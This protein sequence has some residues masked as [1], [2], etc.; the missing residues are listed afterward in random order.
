MAVVGD[1]L[2]QADVRAIYLLHG[3]FVG[4][5]AFGLLREVARVSRKAADP[6]LRFQKQLLDKIAKDA[7]NFPTEYAQAFEEAIN[8]PLPSKQISVRL[9]NW[10]S[11]NHHIGRCD[12]AVRLV[13]ELALHED[14]RG[15]RVL[16]WGHSHG[17]N[18]LALLTNLLGADA[19][20]RDRFFRAARSYYQWPVFGKVDLPTW[21]SVR[22]VLDR[23]DHPLRDMQLDCVTL[24][25]PVRYGWDVSQTSRLLHFVNHRPVP[26]HDPDRAPFPP[27]WDDLLNARYGDYIQQIGIA[28]TNITPPVWAWRAWVADVR[29]DRIL[30]ADI[31]KR[32]LM[33]RLRAGVRAHDEGTSL[34]IDYGPAEGNISQHLAGHAVYTRL[35]WMLFHAEQVAARFYGV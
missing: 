30:Q 34:L 32:D 3:T 8:A 1:A 21:P 18:V 15:G 23:D 6:L 20:T 27:D 13:E 33:E 29:L 35:D 28:G 26:E 4:V 17:G 31:R 19:T 24:G 10:S 5:D 2:R 22:A 12:G 7:G 14:L 9:F 11:E 16:F 25:T